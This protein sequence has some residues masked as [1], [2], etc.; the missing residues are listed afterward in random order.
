MDKI[1]KEAVIKRLAVFLSLAII[2]ALGA[3][4]ISSYVNERQETEIYT[5]SSQ[6]YTVVFDVQTKKGFVYRNDGD[7]SEVMI[8][9]PEKNVGF[10]YSDQGQS[11]VRYDK[12]LKWLGDHR[13]STVY[14]SVV[15]LIAPPR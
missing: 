3:Y 12:Y 11:I 8:I 15:A 5:E 6:S 7:T 14:N 9:H 2:A 1:V 10:V 13:K 4:F